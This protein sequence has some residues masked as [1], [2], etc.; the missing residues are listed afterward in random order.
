MALK[1]PGLLLRRRS[2]QAGNAPATFEASQGSFL[3][4]S[5]PYCSGARYKAPAGMALYSLT[6][7]DKQMLQLVILEKELGLPD[8]F[9]SN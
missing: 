8:S 5:L 7:H 1:L 4:F 9:P 2:L 6:L 3:T